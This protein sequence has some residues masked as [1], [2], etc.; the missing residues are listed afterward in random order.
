MAGQLPALERTWLCGY[1]FSKFGLEIV[2][3]DLGRQWKEAQKEEQQSII[4]K[5]GRFPRSLRSNSWLW[6]PCLVRDSLLTK[7]GPGWMTASPSNLHRA[8]QSQHRLLN[9]RKG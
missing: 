4:V 5:F 2:P 3:Q 9:P 1:R 8:A 7:N 6:K